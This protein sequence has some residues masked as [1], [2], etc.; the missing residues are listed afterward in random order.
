MQNRRQAFGNLTRNLSQLHFYILDL[1]DREI[2]VICVA[3]I[4]SLSTLEE[5]VDI[6]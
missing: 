1:R 5:S 6:V 2:I 4:I 3:F